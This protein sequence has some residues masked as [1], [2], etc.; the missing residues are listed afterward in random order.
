MPTW[1][2]TIYIVARRSTRLVENNIFLYHITGS[3][4]VPRCH[5]IIPFVKRPK[6]SSYRPNVCS[7]ID[8]IGSANFVTNPYCIVQVLNIDYIHNPTLDFLVSLADELTS[9][10]KTFSSLVTVILAASKL[11]SWAYFLLVAEKAPSRWEKT[12]PML[13]RVVL[14]ALPVISKHI[15][16]YFTNRYIHW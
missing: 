3:F 15:T 10:L 4:L 8:S 11:L 14:D 6:I 9:S 2:K 16:A 7:K 5:D 13:T 12:L 1:Y